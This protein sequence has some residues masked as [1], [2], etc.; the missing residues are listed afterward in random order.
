MRAHFLQHVAFEGLGSIATWLE[1]SGYEITSTQLYESAEFPAVES[2]DLLIIMGGPMSVNDEDQFPW[3]AVEKGY[4]RS[5]IRAG[6]PTLGVCLGAQ[7]IAN[8]LGSKVYP[9]HV[10]EI[11]WF[12]ILPVRSA[13]NESTFQFPVEINVFHWH[14]E[15]FD[16]PVGAVHIASSCACSHQ[17]FQIGN[18]TMGLQFHLE[19][20]ADSAQAIV[21]NCRD[22]LVEGRF[23]QA[24]AE[25]LSVQQQQYDAINELMVKILE[26]I[27][28][29]TNRAN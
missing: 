24:E 2:I 12:P 13:N 3:L 20:T 1:K 4:I 10:K 19:T 23:V 17:A 29:P 28:L 18:N 11:G 9:N 16:L 7:L 22:E 21:E 8:A 27:C 26:F 14:G 25:I 6:I 5:V 15:T